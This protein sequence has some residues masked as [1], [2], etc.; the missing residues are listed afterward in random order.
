MYKITTNIEQINLINLAQ[1]QREECSTYCEINKSSNSE[2]YA[3]PILGSI[4]KSYKLDFIT[5]KWLN[6]TISELPLDWDWHSL[7]KNM[8]FKIANKDIANGIVGQDILNI[9]FN[10]LAKDALVDTDIKIVTDEIHTLFYANSISEENTDVNYYIRTI[11][12]EN[13]LIIYSNENGIID[14]EYKRI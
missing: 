3:I 5:D 7:A 10:N 4:L 11:T 9:V 2:Q 13:G 1:S 6:E 8:R 12:D 14:V